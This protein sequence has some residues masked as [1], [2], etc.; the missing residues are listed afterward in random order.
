QTLGEGPGGAVQGLRGRGE[1]GYLQFWVSR[2]AH[3][4]AT[5]MP[6]LGLG[7]G[8]MKDERVRA[9]RLVRRM[10]AEGADSD[11][12]DLVMDLI[13]LE[14]ARIEADTTPYRFVTAFTA[15]GLDEAMALGHQ[16]VDIQ[17]Q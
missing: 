6:W 5:R 14:A 9:N 16:A 17:A 13:E 8:L 12:G 4:V 1:N 15:R 11:G 2:N 3:P 7:V 10:R